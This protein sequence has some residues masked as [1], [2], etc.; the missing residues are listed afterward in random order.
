M[1]EKYNRVVALLEGA[2]GALSSARLAELLGVTSR[3][4]KSYVTQI[5][6]IEPDLIRSTPKG[7][8][9]NRNMPRK[10]TTGASL[11]CCVPHVGNVPQTYAER[12][13]YIIR[14]LLIDHVESIDLYG[15]CDE[16]CLSYSSVKGLIGRMNH[17][18]R[19]L[20]V[21]FRCRAERVYLE[22]NERDKRRFL[23]RAIYRESSGCYVD[24]RAIKMLFED[25][26][27]DAIDEVLRGIV[28]S[29]ALSVS[30][31]GYSNLLLHLAVA[32]DRV[33][34]GNSLSLA[35]GP[36]PVEG[37]SEG[38]KGVTVEIIEGLQERLNVSFG[39]T[40]RQAIDEQ[41]STNLLPHPMS[42]ID[43]IIEDVG[44]RNYRVTAD[45]IASVNARYHLHLNCDALQLPLALHIKNL[46][47]RAERGTV[48]PN[49]F[50]ETMQV[51]C[52]V[53]FDCAV[54]SAEIIQRE[55]GVEISKDEVAYLAM[56]IGADIERQNREDGKLACVLLCPEYYDMQGELAGYLLDHLGQLITLVAVCGHEDEIPET[57]F[58]VLIATVSPAG[59]YGEVVVI[60]PF[61]RAIDMKELI[62]RLQDIADRRKLRAIA[63]SY[64]EF[65]RPALFCLRD[66][67]AEERNDVIRSLSRLLRASN[68]VSMGFLEDVMRREE[69]ASTAFR[70]VAIPH[71]MNMNAQ[72]TG[73]AVAIAPHGIAWGE[74][75][76]HI[77]LLVAIGEHDLP[78]FQELY[79]A[80]ILLFS[81][82]E[83]VASARRCASFDE[84]ERLLLACAG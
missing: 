3:S 42:E 59:E 22:G 45:I 60:P 20:R 77:V 38:L 78:V 50:L 55:Y 54:F 19:G 6:R 27:I 83:F 41:V 48:L 35:K 63:S 79:E 49:P 72:R 69:A 65:F 26:V 84:F 53:L 52:P 2:S 46:V 66:G 76:V 9:L 75:R 1:N 18:Y 30:E 16:L 73:I 57:A 80:L 40:E 12:C 33:A 10:H 4:V 68:Y 14:R 23:T 67:A 47:I 39:V 24:R 8:V 64:R 21:V 62:G 17:E 71:A 58:D 15:L 44:E 34:G 36:F 37:A 56:H 5:N 43:R 32:V 70:D 13:Q 74:G 81:Q 25:R 29:R 28:D 31:F 11:D 61:K 51:S 7:Y 82:E